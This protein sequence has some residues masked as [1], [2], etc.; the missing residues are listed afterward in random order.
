LVPTPPGRTCSALLFSDFVKNKNGISVC[1]REL[2]REFP[3]DISMY[4]YIVNWI[5]LSPLFFFFLP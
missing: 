4:M 1:L 3:Y 5:G 2:H